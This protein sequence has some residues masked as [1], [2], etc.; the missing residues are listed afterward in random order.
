M[1]NFSKFLTLISPIILRVDLFSP[2][3][4]LFRL[5][6][7][8]TSG[9]PSATISRSIYVT[10]ILAL[11]GLLSTISA[12]IFILLSAKLSNLKF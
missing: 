6:F 5:S 9:I 4:S 1:R 7:I 3:N 11:F 12:E 2:V 8:L 10:V